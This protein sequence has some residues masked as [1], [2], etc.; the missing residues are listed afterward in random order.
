MQ[1]H[2][3]AEKMTHSETYRGQS[4]M[5]ILAAYAYNEW[6]LLL[7]LTDG[8]VH[9]LMM[10]RNSQQIFWDNLSPQQAYL[11]Q[12]QLLL[13]SEI[14]TDKKRKMS[15]LPDELQQPLKK[16]RELQVPFDSSLL[17]QLD[18]TDRNA[19]REERLEESLEI[20]HADAHL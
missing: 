12:S 1:E 8:V 5:A 13:S 16:M 7:G 3:A 2:N 4:I 15:T 17:D 9:H 14:L 20:M 6:P 11:K 10:T 18:A 19:Y